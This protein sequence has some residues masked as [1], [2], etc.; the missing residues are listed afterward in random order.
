MDAHQL[1]RLAPVRYAF[2]FALFSCLVMGV[3]LAVIYWWMSTLLQRSLDD[4]IEAQ[5][6]VLRADLEQDG[7]DSMI[8]LVRQH[9]ENYRD[10]TLHLVVQDRLGNV[11]AGDLQKTGVGEGWHDIALPTSTHDINQR[12][13][14]LRGRGEWL[15]DNLFVLVTNDTSDLVQTRMLILRSFAI[16]LAATVILAL[17]GGLVIGIVLLRRVE[18]VNQTA[19]AIMQ[20]DLSQRIPVVGRRDELAGLA[21][22]INRM[23]ARI[24]ELMANL[25]HVTSDIA[26][27]LRTPL[28]RLRQR[29]ETARSRSG[30][31]QDYDA[32]IDAAIE[33][34]DTM[35]K[36]FEAMLRIAQIEAGARRARFANVD[37]GAV[38]EN[39]VDAFTAVAEDEGKR[40]ESKIES[41]VEA[42]GD[43]ELL[44]QMLANLVENAIR[45]TSEHAVLGVRLERAGALARIVV[46]D[47]GPGIPVQERERVFARFYRLDRSRTTAGS[48]LGLSFVAAVTKLHG[49]RVKLEDNHPGLRAIVELGD[50]MLDI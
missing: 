31:E 6:Q 20:G 5:L 26:H 19:R 41:G 33:E 43:R 25:Q 23:L 17:G 1:A 2:V 21:E 44:T 42:H 7:Q 36:T 16:A 38:V 14:I 46:S 37:L 29:L 49:A 12:Q 11:L 48:G 13:R 32:V 22:S 30:T 34:T 15:E 18:A 24:E 4:G 35:L 8:G 45:H 39:I 47:N 10:S 27:D 50:S 3:L 9:E 28:G 40:L